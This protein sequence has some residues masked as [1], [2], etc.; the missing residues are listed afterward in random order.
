MAAALMTMQLHEREE[1]LKLLSMWQATNSAEKSR[2]DFLA[3]VKEIWPDF[4][5]GR[6]HEI[7]A[8]AFNRVANGQ[9]KRLIINMPPRHGKS[10]LGSY[11]LPAWFL[12][13]YPDR[14]IIQASNTGEL[15]IDFGRKVR[16]LIQ[17]DEYAAIF[18][19]VKL[20]S[21][22][23]AAGRWNTNQKGSYFAIG[24]G[25]TVTGKGADIFIIDDPHAEREATQAVSNPQ[26]FTKVY[27]WYTSGPRQ[28]LQPKGAIILIQTRWAKNDLTGKLLAAQSE[29]PS[30]DEWEVIEFPAILPSGAPLWP[31]FWPLPEL[32]GLRASI[33]VSKWQAQYQQ[34]PT[35]EEG[36]IMKREWWMLWDDPVPPTCEAIIQ[37]WDTAHS[38]SDRA[39]YSACTTWGIFYKQDANGKT[40]PHLI[41]ID[42]FRDKLEFPELKKKVKELYNKYSPDQLVVEKTASGGPL[43]FELRSMGIP[44]T[45]FN[46][47]R[48]KN[49][50]IARANSVSDLFAS[51]MVWHPPKK[52]AEEVIEECASFPAGEHDDYVDSCLAG[53]TPV[54]M[55]DGTEKRID[56]VRV[57][58]M[59][60]TPRGARRVTRFLD[61]G[62]REVWMVET[63][64]RHILATAD[65][66]VMTSRGWVRVDSL[67]PHVDTVTQAIMGGESWVSKTVALLRRLWFSMGGVITDT[68]KATTPLTGGTSVAQDIVFT[69][70]FG[71]HTT[72]QSQMGVTSTTSTE[73]LATTAYQTLN[74]W[75]ARITESF[76]RRTCPAGQGS[77][78][79]SI[80]LRPSD[81]PPPRG[82]PQ[83]K[84]GLGIGNTPEAHSLPPEP[85]RLKT[86]PLK[87]LSCAF[88]AALNILA[89]AAGASFALQHVRRRRADSGEVKEAMNTRT[90]LQVYD[91]E[92]DGE[93]CFYAD[94]IMVHNCT[95]ALIRYRQGGWIGTAYDEKDDEKAPVSR[96]YY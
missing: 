88:G 80:I 71:K 82:T 32:E 66:L 12:G 89:G 96:G 1:V 3:F 40:S 55:A 79:T 65:H 93:H 78:N 20:A 75:P 31:D 9:L 85:Q 29:D 62:V 34:N 36:A 11:L 42:A 77:K 90:M 24:V 38:K 27:N 54:L 25:G 81:Q 70:T 69:E 46:P 61:R 86:A 91:L 67:V 18:P 87:S 37:S 45:E 41:L 60:S 26:I 92:V 39:D 74:A 33:P 47:G 17:S 59:V 14:K 76:T 43:I 49:D 72:A 10:E 8:D 5:C 58:D 84:A 63:A 15:A 22:S 19:G 7:M 68:R 28:R 23:K 21:D 73:I 30:A 83:R 44:V 16:N 48:G 64:T 94:G 2:A 51:G 13:K 56:S 35:S 52:W 95:Q 6:H 4:I 57:G 50:K 53:E